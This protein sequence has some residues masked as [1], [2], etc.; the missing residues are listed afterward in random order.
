[1]APEVEV[2]LGGGGI[3]KDFAFHENRLAAASRFAPMF[4][5][6]L[7]SQFMGIFGQLGTTPCNLRLH[8]SEA[9]LERLGGEESVRQ[10]VEQMQRMPPQG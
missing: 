3:P 6:E 10:V 9:L 4:D 7:A 8:L 1:M 2:V 5:E